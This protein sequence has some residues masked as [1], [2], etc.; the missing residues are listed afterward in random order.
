M[1]TQLIEKLV[2]RVYE[3]MGS[4]YTGNLI[5]TIR[6]HEGGIR[7]LTVNE[8]YPLKVEQDQKKAAP[9]KTI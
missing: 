4:K 6:L 9:R 3:L 2:D 5:I 7:Q 8:E 1:K